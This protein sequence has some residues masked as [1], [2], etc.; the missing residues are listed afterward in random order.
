MSSALYS[1]IDDKAD[2]KT[3]KLIGW[4][5]HIDYRLLDG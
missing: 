5:S 1:L 3:S 2:I 4:D